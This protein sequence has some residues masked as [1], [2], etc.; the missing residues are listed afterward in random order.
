MRDNKV[1]NVVEGRL[2]V[3]VDMADDAP[4]YLWLVRRLSAKFHIEVLKL[5]LL[6]AKVVCKAAKSRTLIFL[7]F[8]VLEGV[9]VVSAAAAVHFGVARLTLL[10]PLPH[11]TGVL[12]QA[13]VHNAWGG[14]CPQR[15][16]A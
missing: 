14:A 11:S 5:D 6:A 15:S 1:M 13:R 4:E 8:F 12:L 7:A 16:G 2:R 3:A 9:Y 10:Y